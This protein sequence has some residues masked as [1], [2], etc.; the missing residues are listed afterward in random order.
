MTSYDMNP[1][2]YDMDLLASAPKATTRR[3]QLHRQVCYNFPKHVANNNSDKWF[4]L[5]V[6][7]TPQIIFLEKK[8]HHLCR[9]II[10]QQLL[11]LLTL[12]Q[13]TVF[14]LMF[15]ENDTLTKEKKRPFCTTKKGIIIVA[16]AVL[17]IVILAVVGGV[18]G[19]R[20]SSSSPTD[21]QDMGSNVSPTPSSFGLVFGPTS[22]KITVK[23]IQIYNYTFT[24][25]HAPINLKGGLIQTPPKS[26]FMQSTHKM[27]P[28]CI[29]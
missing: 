8:L 10:P 1:Y 29:F 13:L 15:N 5:P 6:A 18:V 27:W 22:V 21:G 12:K 14:R 23:F 11:L 4:R 3:A 2:P 9:I 16:V 25:Y 20:K 24:T 7:I 28:K 17:V 26:Q 19:S